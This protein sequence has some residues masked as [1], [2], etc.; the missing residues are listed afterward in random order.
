MLEKSAVLSRTRKHR[1][2]VSADGTIVGK[3]DLRR[4]RFR[5]FPEVAHVRLRAGDRTRLKAVADK[6]RRAMSELVR[7][8]IEVVLERRAMSPDRRPFRACAG[9]ARLS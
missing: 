7:E 2:A 1:K 5:E 9:S 8:A 4:L 6:A 3:L